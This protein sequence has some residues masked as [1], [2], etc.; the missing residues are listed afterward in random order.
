ME[1]ADALTSPDTWATHTHV[2]ATRVDHAHLDA[3][4]A[5]HSALSV[6]DL[7][8]EVVAYADEE[9]ATRGVTG[10]VAISISDD[11]VSVDDDGRGTDTRFADDGRVIRK[12]VMSTQ[13][14]R[15]FGRVDAPLLPNGEPRRGMSVVSALSE[16]LTHEN[17]R[18]SGSWIQNYSF[19]V[20]D[21]ELRD[22]PYRGSTGTLVSFSVRE[23][24]A[25]DLSRLGSQ[26]AGF[27]D[28]RVEI[29]D[30]R[31]VSPS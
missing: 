13:D 17:H 5:S 25:L 14:V 6:E 12:P 26:C 16:T 7:I 4:R 18:T 23:T 15:F 31:S 1:K 2:W 22:V 30:H 19:G 10:N 20:P 21:E 8:L 28:I 9:A 11:Q 3:V 29:H 24:V 27:T